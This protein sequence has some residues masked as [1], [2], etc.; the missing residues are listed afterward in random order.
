MEDGY[1]EWVMR[2]GF[3]E[4]F[5]PGG[6]PDG[7]K[8]RIPHDGRPDEWQWVIKQADIPHFNSF[9]QDKKWINFYQGYRWE[10]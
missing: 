3:L 10:D 5:P 7:P 9:I 1:H 6:H 4:A 2:P 8:L